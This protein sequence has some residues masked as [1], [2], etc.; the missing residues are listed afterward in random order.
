MAKSPGF[1]AVAAFTLALG[2]G[3][4]SAVF[5]IL[6]E[7]FLRPIPLVPDQDRLVALGRTLDDGEWE[8]FTHP[9]LSLVLVIGAG[10]LVRMLDNLERI[11]LGF[12]TTHLLIVPLELRPQGYPDS[13][14]RLLQ[15]V[16]ERLAALPGAQ[17][18][19]LAKDPPVDVFF[20]TTREILV[21]GRGSS[22]GGTRISVDEGRV[23]TAPVRAACAE[24]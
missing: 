17:S 18:V 24:P 11:D 16:Q 4:N 3:A 15:Q 12:D 1:T 5:S 22:L 20:S 7:I 19:S 13:R 8:G 9:A 2:I 23:A 6:N 21:D 10:L 14:V